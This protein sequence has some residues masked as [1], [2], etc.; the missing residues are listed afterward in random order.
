VQF[1]LYAISV[2][3]QLL[4]FSKSFYLQSDNNKAAK[5]SPRRWSVNIEKAALEFHL[6]VN[7]N[8][9]D[10]SGQSR[11]LEQD[12]QRWLPLAAFKLRNNRSIRHA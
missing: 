1:A 8:I 12:W 2:C 7:Q 11:I 3:R 6:I 9:H 5:L 10:D 4:L